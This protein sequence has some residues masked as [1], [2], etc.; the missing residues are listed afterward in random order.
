MMIVRARVE[1]AAV[2]R[3]IMR[4]AFAEYIGLLDRTSSSHKGTVADVERV[5]REGGAPR[6]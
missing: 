5:I 2:V 6:G 1:D 3:D 4:A